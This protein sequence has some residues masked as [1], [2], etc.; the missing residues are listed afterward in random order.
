MQKHFLPLML[1]SLTAT[2][3][4]PPTSSTQLFSIPKFLPIKETSCT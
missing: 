4:A 3:L 2:A 1:A